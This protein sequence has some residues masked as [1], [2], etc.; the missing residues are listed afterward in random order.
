M[1]WL[2]ILLSGIVQGYGFAAGGLRG[3]LT[4]FVFWV[5][6]VSAVQFGRGA[7]PDVEG[8]M[9]RSGDMACGIGVIVGTVWGAWYGRWEWGWAWMLGGAVGGGFSVAICYA[10]LKVLSRGKSGWE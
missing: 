3:G 7:E 10:V 2:G 1:K 8:G 6:I 4:T 5:L 9:S